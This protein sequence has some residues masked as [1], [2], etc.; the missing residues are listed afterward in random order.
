MEE[1]F[2]QW[3]I[4][5]VYG[6][7]KYAGKVSETNI[8][9]VGMLM[10]EVPEITNQEV[11][12]PGFTKLLGMNSIFSLTIVDEE[13]AREMARKL[14]KHPVEGY[15]HKEVIRQLARKA[16]EEMTLTEIKRLVAVGA[17]NGATDQS[18]REDS[19]DFDF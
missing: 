15:E 3:A 11:T 4:I 9:G 12:L 10:L 1:K 14:S 17:L 5:E 16:T 2:S 13:Y 8:A 6:H 7:E 18:D 19:E